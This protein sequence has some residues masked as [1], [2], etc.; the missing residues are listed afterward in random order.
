MLRS[1]EDLQLNDTELQ[2]EGTLT[3]NTNTCIV[4]FTLVSRLILIFDSVVKVS[5]TDG[6]SLVM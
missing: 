1:L 3:R 2:T 4:C 5:T 6:L